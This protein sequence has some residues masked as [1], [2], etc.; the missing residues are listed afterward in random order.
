VKP[1]LSLTFPL[2][3][4]VSLCGCGSKFFVRG[5]INTATISGTVSMVQLTTIIEDGT[6]VTVTLVT[7]LQSGTG[8]NMN[9]CGDQQSLFPLDQF[10]KASFTTTPPCASIVQIVIG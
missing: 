7:F 2:I 8:R 3:L 1:L 4:L 10:V 9:F 5:A 6:S